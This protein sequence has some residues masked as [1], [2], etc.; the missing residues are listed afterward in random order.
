MPPKK[1]PAWEHS[2]KFQGDYKE[3]PTG[4]TK[5]QTKAFCVFGCPA[6]VYRKAE[7]LNNHLAT[8]LERLGKNSG[9]KYV[10]SAAPDMQVKYAAKLAS[11]AAWIAIR[12]KTEEHRS[13]ILVRTRDL[14]PFHALDLL[15]T[16]ILSRE[17][18][19]FP[20]TRQPAK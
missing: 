3:T 2:T 15:P 1:D 18:P 16:M 14:L 19:A 4:E 10:T 20:Q 8:P 6:F 12:N 13:E 5:T 11:R 9:L 7:K 17:H